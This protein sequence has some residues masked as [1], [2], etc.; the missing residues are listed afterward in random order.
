MRLPV[1]QKKQKA[2]EIACLLPFA[3]L[4]VYY[5]NPMTLRP[6]NRQLLHAGRFSIVNPNG[7][8]AGR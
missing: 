6:H 4:P 1:W 2:N 7:V 8:D 3:N 5:I